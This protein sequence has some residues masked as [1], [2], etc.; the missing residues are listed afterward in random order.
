VIA[1]K[2]EIGSKYLTKK[3]LPVTVIGPKGD[4]I[5]VRLETTG[6]KIEVEKGYELLPFDE[7]KLNKDARLLLKA[8]GTPKNG[9]SN[10]GPKEGSLAA[11]ID[12]MLFSGSHTVKEIA[13]ELTKEAAAADK[14]KDLEANVRARLFSFR[15]KGCRVEKDSQKRIRV[16]I[17]KG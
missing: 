4:R 2:A 5:V 14:G 3:G 1:S 12:P 11:I 7:G 10:K 16:V 13:A 6:N 17:K 9:I 15:R 8:K